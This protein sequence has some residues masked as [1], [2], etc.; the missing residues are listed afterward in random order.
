MDVILLR[1]IHRYV[2]ATD[3]AILMS[4]STKYNYRYNMS[5]TLY[6]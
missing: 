3:V 2:S 6:V 4:V 1:I 5:D